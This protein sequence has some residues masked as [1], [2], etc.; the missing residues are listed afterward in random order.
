M[1][2]LPGTIEIAGVWRRSGA[3]LFDIVIIVGAVFATGYAWFGLDDVWREYHDAPREFD[4]AL[5]YYG[6]RSIVRNVSLVLYVVYSGVMDASRLQGT[7]GKWLLGIGVVDC[8]GGRLTY[9]QSVLRNSTKVVSF[10]LVI[11]LLVA[12]RTP[13]RQTW[14]DRVAGTLVVRMPVRLAGTP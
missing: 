5:R 9:Q 6:A 7:L 10:V 14:H 2:P 13:A 11:G 4:A 12:L 3:Y 1:D 8:E